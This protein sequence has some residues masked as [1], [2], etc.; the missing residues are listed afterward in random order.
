MTYHDRFLRAA[1][2]AGLPEDESARFADL[3][4][5]FR[6]RAGGKPGS[7]PAGRFGGLPHL[8]AETPWP[9]VRPGAPLAY[10]L[11]LDCTALPEVSGLALPATGSLL[12][13]LSAAAAVESSSRESEQQVARV[14]FVPAGTDTTPAEPPFDEFD[15]EPLSG[16]ETG[17]F[18]DVEP[19]LPEWLGRPGNQLTDFQRHLVRE[20]P[21]LAELAALVERLW[22]AGDP[23][24]GDDVLIGG[25][26]ISAQNS[27]ETILAAD[28]SP[29]AE[30]RVMRDWVA[31][32]QFAAPHDEYVNGRFL[33]RHD[34][35]AAGRFDRALSFC[36]FTE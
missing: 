2:E 35:L 15:D 33:I 32:A 18:A 4:L 9:S 20:M 17:L 22:P 12:F 19:H 10:I 3:I 26:S 30:L 14:L 34:D 7:V 29:E 8:P 28:S 31:L 16:P 6:I 5:R 27:P 11:A 21:H 24:I 1:G 25:Y 36:E 13:F 23:W